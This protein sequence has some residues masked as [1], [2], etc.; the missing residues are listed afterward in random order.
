MP[1]A[2]VPWIASF[3]GLVKPYFT[4]NSATA[5]KSVIVL[6]FVALRPAWCQRS[7]Y[8]PPPRMCAIA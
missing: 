7:P 5:M 6:I 2:L 8:S 1:P 4:R 3:F